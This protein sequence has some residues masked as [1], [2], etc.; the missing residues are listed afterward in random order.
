MNKYLLIAV[1]VFLLGIYIYLSKQPNT[2]ISVLDIP[3][4]H[5]QGVVIP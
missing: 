5:L 2:T 3:A 1:V 4:Q